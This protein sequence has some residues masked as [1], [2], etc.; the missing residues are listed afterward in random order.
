MAH[1]CKNGIPSLSVERVLI[2]QDWLSENDFL[3]PSLFALLEL[4]P[5]A[6]VGFLKNNRKNIPPQLADRHIEFFGARLSRGNMENLEA[7]IRIQSQIP[8]NDFDLVICNTR[9]YLRHLRRNLVDSTRVVVYQHDLLPFIWRQDMKGL[10]SSETSDLLRDQELD[11]EYAPG[12]DLTIAANFSLQK[13]L[14]ALTK[15]NI[16][17]AYPLIDDQT[18]FPDTEAEAEYFVA[19][20]GPEVAPLIHLMS[21]V[22]DKLVVLGESHPDKLLRDLKIGNIYYTGKIKIPDQAYYLGGARALI[23]GETRTLSHL[24]LAALKAGI[25]VIAHPTQGMHE[26]LADGESGVELMTS[27]PDDVLHHIRRYRKSPAKK[28]RIATSVQWLNKEYFLRRM[29]KALEKNK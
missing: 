18:F 6:H 12:I 27:S 20:D 9:G 23:C 4:F 3:N 7:L 13:S 11:L 28:N 15:K 26:F 24:P 16:P 2:L 17:L 14:M 1:R 5:Q 10:S 8:W 21:C 22:S 19:T 29:R 25:P